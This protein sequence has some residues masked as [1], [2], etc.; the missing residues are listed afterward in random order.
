MRSRIESMGVSMPGGI[1]ARGSVD[2]A[3][4][5]GKRCI[6]SSKYHRSEIESLVN[7]GVFRDNH[8]GEPAMAAFIQEGLGINTSFGTAGTFS[9]DLNNGGAGMLT[10]LQAID[11][12]MRAGAVRVAMAVTSEANTDRKPDPNYN[13]PRSGAAVIMERSPDS[14]R[15]FGS[16]VF[17]TFDEHAGESVSRVELYKKGG[18]L[19][20]EKSGSLET[21][22]LDCA[23]PVFDEL[24]ER[25]EIGRDEIDLVIPSQVSEGFLAGLGESLGVDADKVVNVLDETGGDTH[26][27]SIIIAMNTAVSRGLAAPGTRAVLLAVGSGITV[28][29]A[30]YIF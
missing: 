19:T 7:A 28:G 13:Y 22:Y 20:I 14:H 29:C 9:F 24:L 17:R 11:A 2:H 18:H 10:A 23:R 27:S 21:S 12:M 4:A 26:T 3:V 16:F 25:E 6:E 1:I 30:L 8:C 15:G 5:A